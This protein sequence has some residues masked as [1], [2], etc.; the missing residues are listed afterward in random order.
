MTMYALG[1]TA[2]LNEIKYETTEIKHVAY[3]DD[4]TGAGKIDKLKAWWDLIEI[5]GPEVG[6]QPNARKSFL[7]V[8]P[9]Y[10]ERAVHLFSDSDVV[11][12][13]EGQRHLGAAIGTADF[14]KEF[15]QEKV[16]EWVK[17]IETLSNFAKTEPHAA[18]TAF[19]HG[20]KHR[21]NYLMRTIPD[22]SPLLQ[23]LE[24]AIKDS[25]LSVLLKGHQLSDEERA[26]LALPPRL[27]GLGI[28]NPVEMAATEHQNSIR[29]TAA[30]TENI[31]A[32]NAD[33]EINMEEQSRIRQ[34]IEKE[35]QQ[36]QQAA[37]HRLTLLLPDNLQR[38]LNIAQEVGA[39]N[40][41]TT[42]LIQAKGFCLNK[43]EFCDTLALRCG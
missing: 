39:S 34:T 30:L 20:I 40:W 38:R 9:E 29:L 14:R 7:I 27:G 15:V 1:L 8:K 25:F 23:P 28:V 18:Y 21:W 10:Y 2:L 5:H 42:L 43:H 22:V 26:I 3:A 32:Q 12:A 37:L 33:E 6:Y 35:R 31:V 16:N 36:A 4:L 24:N 41:L 17:E 19:T 11:I 13:P